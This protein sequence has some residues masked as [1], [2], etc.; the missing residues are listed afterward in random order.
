MNKTVL[1]FVA[2][3]TFACA[4]CNEKPKTEVPRETPKAE[5][6]QPQ[7][8]ASPR[9]QTP[10]PAP[11]RAVIPGGDP[12]AEKKGQETP[13]AFAKKGKVI[14][15]M[16]AG[17]Y[18]YVEVAGKKGQKTWL[19][20]PETTVSEGD[21]IEFPETPPLLNFKSKPLDRTFD[22]ICFVPGIRVA[23]KQAE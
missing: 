3:S 17:G 10:P 5:T 9:N 14:Q 21:S 7:T 15:T 20:L 12:Y 8:A 23:K 4:G 16:N 18:T 13:A 22:R 11:A 2:I 1:A 19:A 6:S